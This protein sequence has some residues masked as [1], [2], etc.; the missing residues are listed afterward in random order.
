MA[1]LSDD[2]NTWGEH[3]DEETDTYV[4]VE[5]DKRTIA[6]TNYVCVT[7]KGDPV[8]GHFVL[9]LSLSPPPPVHGI[10][11]DKDRK[12]LTLHTT[13][14]SIKAEISTK[15]DESTKSNRVSLDLSSDNGNVCAVVHDPFCP[16]R[17]SGLARPFFDIALRANYGDISLS[18][19]RCFHGPI[20]IRTGDE[21]IAF[22]PEF[23]ECASIILDVPSTKVYF[24][25]D[26]PHSGKWG[27]GSSDNGESEED[28]LDELTVDGRF[29]SVRIHW[30]G[31]DEVPIMRPNGWK[32][33]C[34]AAERFLT[35]GRVC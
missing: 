16:D 30:D 28:P 25:G 12:N 24:V 9:D 19:P 21:R 15:H 18:L 26:R 5:K 10:S 3:Q 4:S 20:T 32:V 1:A 13:S 11:S 29:T 2:P 6:P 22:S 27:S 31:D 33:L 34:G 8:D 14:G 35:T 17:S 23:K 7:K